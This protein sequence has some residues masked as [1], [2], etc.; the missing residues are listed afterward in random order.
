MYIIKIKNKSQQD[1]SKGYNGMTK[2]NKK[3]TNI[4]NDFAA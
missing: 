3:K 2:K 4:I 1:I